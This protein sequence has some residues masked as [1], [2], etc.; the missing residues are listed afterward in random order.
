MTELMAES[1][2]ES[3]V[4]S[5]AESSIPLRIQSINVNKKCPS[6]LRKPWMIQVKVSLRSCIEMTLDVSL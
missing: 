6:F 5:A 4:E 1:V 2:T 3:M